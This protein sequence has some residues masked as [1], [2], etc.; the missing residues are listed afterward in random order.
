MDLW[1]MTGEYFWRPYQERWPVD[2]GYTGRKPLYQLLWCVEYAQYSNER[3]HL[4]ITQSLCRSLGLPVIE[5]FEPLRF[6]G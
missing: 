4:E 1:Q 6:S 5:S 2:K 3:E